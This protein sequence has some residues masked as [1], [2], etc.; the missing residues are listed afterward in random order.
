MKMK[1]AKR[2]IAIALAF[3]LAFSNSFTME[4]HASAMDGVDNPVTKESIQEDTEGTDEVSPESKTEEVENTQEE[5]KEDSDSSEETGEETDTEE[6]KASEDTETVEEVP[7]EEET[8]ESGLVEE[9]EELVGSVAAVY[10]E[11][12]TIRLSTKY[13]NSAENMQKVA[14]IIP[15]TV[16]IK[17]TDGTIT[18]STVSAWKVGTDCFTGTVNT[19]DGT[20][21]VSITVTTDANSQF[22]GTFDDTSLKPGATFE[23][24]IKRNVSYDVVHSYRIKKMGNGYDV[25]LRFDKTSTSGDTVTFSKQTATLND[26]GEYITFFYKSSADPSERTCVVSKEIN[27]LEVR[28]N[29]YV[30]DVYGFTRKLYIASAM[31]T[32]EMYEKIAQALPHEACV[33]S[34]IGDIAEVK[35]TGAWTYDATLKSGSTTVGG[36]VNTIDASSLPSNIADKGVLATARAEIICPTLS[37]E[38]QISKIKV[39]PESGSARTG[40]TYTFAIESLESTY[41]SVWLC[42]FTDSNGGAK[43][44]SQTDSAYDSSKSKDKM[45][46]YNVSNVQK[47]DTG[48]YYAIVCDK[49]TQLSTRDAY[50]AVTPATLSIN[51]AAANVTAAYAEFKSLKVG[52]TTGTGS[53]GNIARIAKVLPKTIHVKLST[54]EVMDV[55]ADG[56]WTVNSGYFSNSVS[57]LTGIT[58][59]SNLLKN[60]KIT[61][62][63]GVSSSYTITASQTTADFHSSPKFTVNN[64]S[65]S[66]DVS[67]LYNISDNG[68]LI[69]DSRTASASELTS[70]TKT[71]TYTLN[72]VSD[73]DSG[74]YVAFYFNSSKDVSLRDAMVSRTVAA[75]KVAHTNIVTGEATA[76]TCVS[77]GKSGQT[78]CKDCG[79]VISTGGTTLPVD[80]TN[81]PSAS[82]VNYPEE[83][84]TCY[85]EGK[86]AGQYCNACKKWIKERTA[87][88]KTA[89]TP[90]VDFTWSSDGTSCTYTVTCKVSGCGA[91]ITSGDAAI[92]QT[93]QQAATCSQEGT[94]V[95]SATATYNGKT[96][97]ATITKTVNIDLDKTNH[98]NIVKIPD[99]AAT[100]SSTGRTGATQCTGCKATVSVGTV[101]QKNP[102]VHTQ[103]VTDPAVKATCVS[104][105]KT[106]GSHCE[107][108]NAVIKAQTIIPK[109]NHNAKVKFT[110]SADYATCSYTISC[111]QCNNNKVASGSATVTNKETPATSCITPGKKTYTATVAFEGKTYTDTCEKTLYADKTD[112]SMHKNIETGAYVVPTCTKGGYTN[113]RTCKDCGY[114]FEGQSDGTAPNPNAHPAGSIREDE[115]VAPT[116]TKTGLTEGSHCEDCKAAIKKQEE[117]PMLDHAPALEY[118]WSEDHMTCMMKMVCG[119]CETVLQEEQA[120]TATKQETPATCNAYGKATYTAGI[121]YE[122][123]TY[124]AT[125][126]EEQLPLDKENHVVVTDPAVA[127]TCEEAG[128]TE[129]SHCSVCNKVLVAPEIVPATGHVYAV[130]SPATYVAPEVQ[131]CGICG[132]EITIGET[133]YFKVVFDGNGA[134]KTS[135]NT[136]AMESFADHYTNKTDCIPENTYILDGKGFLEWNTTK[137]GSGVRIADKCTIYDLVTK[138]SSNFDSEGKITLYAQW[139]N[140]T[141]AAPKITKT[142]GVSNG[143]RLT[144]TQS[145]AA[146][147]F[148]VYRSTSKSSWQESSLL[149]TITDSDVRTYTDTKVSSGTTYYYKVVAGLVNDSPDSNIVEVKTIGTATV[150]SLVNQTKGLKVSWQAVKN[151][152]GYFVY[153]SV[154]GGSY[155]KVQTTTALSYADTSA[156]TNKAKYQ[157][158]IE[159][160]NTFGKVTSGVATAYK[161]AAPAKPTLTN[162]AKGVRVSWKAVSGVTGYYV[163][164]SINGAAYKKV[165]TVKGAKTVK[166]LDKGAKTNG[167]KYQYQIYAYY[168]AGGKT[169]TS[170]ASSAGTVYFLKQMKINSARNT[171]TRNL[172]VKWA[173]NTSATGYQIQYATSKKF[174]GKK[175]VKITSKKT[176]TK[177][178]NRLKKKKTYYVRVRAYKK[179]GKVTSYSAW[180]KTKKVKITK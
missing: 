116:C 127:A 163:Y 65:T 173:K 82:I 103:E 156:N 95:N 120:I 14:A 147:Q 7:Y 44:Y 139:A 142:E 144:W 46:Y 104:A 10:G 52:T 26:D 153:R 123:K 174:S 136:S 170:C 146:K 105:G 86:T 69:Y 171:K 92:S 110:W 159:A 16:Y 53:A 175:T 68:G 119:E 88:S 81:H 176:V 157:Y 41:N 78:Y 121:T 24:K 129:G 138:L 35:T 72:N 94:A 37:T 75:L 161:V 30:E 99:V 58:D 145:G 79:D 112:E 56:E 148:K 74:D 160:Y 57:G 90:D 111:D 117:V 115:A 71:H 61:Y 17:S 178:I 168:T 128:F 109:L 137:D 152:T 13:K 96:Y 83:P 166:Y 62:T 124:E 101:I 177:K 33:V 20:K 135:E 76:A 73:S 164:R 150:P 45:F 54:G 140:E 47:A 113:A 28:N 49:T 89:H 107:D 25:N 36:F 154:N 39:T 133:A 93:I 60:I 18:T 91:S 122:G 85:K 155:T 141:P 5:V 134:V 59:S 143:I 167:K 15:K 169:Y 172:T 19:A 66:Y 1:I 2:W 6:G 132:K 42:K 31:R 77:E 87:I 80:P 118:Q 3:V 55:Q 158:K 9:N 29:G 179:S 50:I 51:D 131:C 40:G 48:N 34:D 97:K 63:T 180:S 102:N 151:A 64:I 165:A 27:T 70:G 4:V 11:F 126:Y 21:E 38:T 32:N 67:Q 108:C 98:T 106:E 130:K 43:I 162:E 149:A 100:C 84:A 22:Y 23:Y 125:P 12:K 114:T 8:M